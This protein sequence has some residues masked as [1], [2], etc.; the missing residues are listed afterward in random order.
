MIPPEGLAEM[1]TGEPTTMSRSWTWY[2]SMFSI[3]PSKGG[4][5]IRWRKSDEDAGKSIKLVEPYVNS[6][7]SGL[8]FKT[9]EGLVD[10]IVNEVVASTWIRGCY[11]L[12]A[13]V[14]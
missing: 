14:E 9:E 1:K 11:E 6:T 10:V 12:L 8:Q 4:H 5:E 13:G 3:H 2:G 7:E